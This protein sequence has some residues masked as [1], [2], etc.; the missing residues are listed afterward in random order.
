[1]YPSTEE[2][3]QDFTEHHPEGKLEL[4][5]G[6]LIAGNSLIGS[7]LLLRQILQ[8]WKADAAV[9]LAPVEL[10][11]EAL[12]L[13]FKLSTPGSAVESLA[14]LDALEAGLGQNRPTGR[15]DCRAG[16]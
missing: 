14:G 12:K 9:A 15:P 10:W 11:I 5:E 3:F 16:R 6:S 4:I 1:M 2:L 13:G 7:R 8:G